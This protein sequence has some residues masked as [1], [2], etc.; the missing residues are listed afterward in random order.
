MLFL[1]FDLGQERYALDVRQVTEVLPLLEL[2]P[3]PQAPPG[4][5]GLCNLRGVPLP[6]VDLCLLV[7]GRAA[8]PRLSTRLVIVAY[9]DPAQRHRLGLIA[10]QATQT[11]RRAPEDFV[12]TGFRQDET[13]YLGPVTRVNDELV[14]WV[15][16]QKLLPESVRDRLYPLVGDG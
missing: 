2:R 12:E 10:E 5:V 7:T 11:L 9:G 16:V 14:Q 13:P 8:R 15:D 4:V 6:V 1:L 3:L